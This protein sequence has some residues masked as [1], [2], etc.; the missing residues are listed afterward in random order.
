[1]GV[2]EGSMNERAIQTIR[3]ALAGHAALE[4]ISHFMARQRCDNALGCAQ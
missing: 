1:M 3:L 4:I 2:S